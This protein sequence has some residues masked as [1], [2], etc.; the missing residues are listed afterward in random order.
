MLIAVPVKGKAPPLSQIEKDL[1]SNGPPP[2]Y[3]DAEEAQS[4]AIVDGGVRRRRRWN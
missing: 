1:A 4:T 2:S 3:V